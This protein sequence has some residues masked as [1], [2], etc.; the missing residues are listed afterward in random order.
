M[1][2]MMCDQESLR[3]HRSSGSR[4]PAA[5]DPATSA[6]TEAPQAISIAI[7]RLQQ[8][9]DHADVRPSRAEPLPRAMPIF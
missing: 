3:A 9:P 6:P 2:P 5:K 4:K 1:K 8:A 7:P